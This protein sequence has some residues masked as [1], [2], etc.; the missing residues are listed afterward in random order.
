VSPGIGGDDRGFDRDGGG[1]DRGEGVEVAGDEARSVASNA[2]EQGRIGERGVFDGFGE[3]GAG[4]A[5]GQGGEVGGVDED[6]AGLVKGTDEVL[7]VGQVDA[8]LAADAAVDLREH[9]GGHERPGQAAEQG[10]GDESGD[11][12]DDAAAERDD[13]GVAVDAGGEG[14]LIK[15]VHGGEGFVV[16]AGRNREQVHGDGAVAQ[17][18]DERGGVQGGD[19]LVGDDDD[20]AGRGEGGGALDELGQGVAAEVDRAGAR[21]FAGQRDFEVA[22]HAAASRCRRASTVSATCS[23]VRWSVAMVRSASA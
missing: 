6:P 13:G 17:G 22:V 11:V 18:G 2:V 15:G 12:A 7:A 9:G 4:L 8:G 16:F 20:A 1:D 21:R 23:A 14:G 19:G 5:G 10:G 3:A